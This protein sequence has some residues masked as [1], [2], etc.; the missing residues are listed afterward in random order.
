MLLSMEGVQSLQLV[1]W[2]KVLRSQEKDGSIF[3]SP[4]STAVVMH[5]GDKM[6]H[7]YLSSLLKKFGNSG[8]SPGFFQALFI[9]MVS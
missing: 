2:R 3:G 1:D 5:T 8:E 6:C 7:G 9:S 4:A